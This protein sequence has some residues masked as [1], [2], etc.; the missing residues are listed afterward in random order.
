MTKSAHR[1]SMKTL[2]ATLLKNLEANIYAAAHK[3]I[4]E[5]SGSWDKYP[6]HWGRNRIDSHLM[7]DNYIDWRIASRKNLAFEKLLPHRKSYFNGNT[8]EIEQHHPVFTF[9]VWP[10]LFC[11]TARPRTNPIRSFSEPML[12]HQ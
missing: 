9:G 8:L 10:L 1:Y 4:I 6:W 11:A 2:A 5:T 3:A 7:G 12:R